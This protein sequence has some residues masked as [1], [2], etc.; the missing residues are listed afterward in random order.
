MVPPFGGLAVASIGKSSLLCGSSGIA[1]TPPISARVDGGNHSCPGQHKR[2]KFTDFPVKRIMR[3]SSSVKKEGTISTS[4][5][6]IRVH[7][8]SKGT[9]ALPQ[10]KNSPH[11]SRSSPSVIQARIIPSNG[12]TTRCKMIEQTSR[13]AISP[14]REQLYTTDVSAP[15]RSCEHISHSDVS[16]R[17]RSSGACNHVHS[18]LS[19]SSPVAAGAPTPVTGSPIFA[20]SKASVR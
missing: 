2:M 15:P 18:L 20:I 19:V 16:N 12:F 8:S 4:S 9:D 11:G 7:K 13:V 5:E 10:T 3:A 14:T 1:R 17:I 6:Y